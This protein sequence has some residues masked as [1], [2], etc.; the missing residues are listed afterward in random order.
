MHVEAPEQTVTIGRG[1]AS[2]KVDVR[3]DSSAD[4]SREHLAIRR[5][6]SGRFYVSD[7]SMLGTTVNGQR[8]PR[9]Y[10]EV[11]G[12]RARNGVETPLPSPARIGLA[13][14]VFLDFEILSGS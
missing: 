6:P 9:G 7:F 1:G 11:D 3:I 8:V 5:D 13:D 2:H 10:D 12:V 14:L 4:I